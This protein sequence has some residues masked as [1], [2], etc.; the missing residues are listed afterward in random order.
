MAASHEKNGSEVSMSREKNLDKRLALNTKRLTVVPRK[1]NTIELDPSDLMNK[2]VKEIDAQ[3]S[4]IYGYIAMALAMRQHK[5][6]MENVEAPPPAP[7]RVATPNPD[8]R[9]PDCSGAVTIRDPRRNPNALPANPP[10][11]VIWVAGSAVNNAREIIDRCPFGIALTVFREEFEKLHVE[12]DAHSYAKAL[13]RLKSTKHVIIYKKRLF[14]YNRLK[15]FLEDLKARLVEDIPEE[16]PVVTGKWSTAVFE[17]IRSHKGAF[18][19]YGDIVGHV[20][21]QPG[22]ENASNASSQVAVALKNLQYRHGSIEKIKE[23]GK[24]QYR[25]KTEDQKDKPPGDEATSADQAIAE[26]CQ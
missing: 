11:K 24:S 16:Q 14:T 15:Q 2:A 22:F 9:A 26:L 6:A 20:T 13:Q 18:V 10:K 21:R 25:L 7:P 12:C 8:S 19:D 5:A 4:V 17:F 1:P 23:R 3:L